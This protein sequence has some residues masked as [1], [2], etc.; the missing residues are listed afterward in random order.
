[1][2]EP[3]ALGFAIVGRLVEEQCLAFPGGLVDQLGQQGGVAALLVRE[4][5]MPGFQLLDAELFHATE[6]LTQDAAQN[7]GELYGWLVQRVRKAV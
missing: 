1:M 3:K 2:Q 7:V 4:F 5:R 6:M